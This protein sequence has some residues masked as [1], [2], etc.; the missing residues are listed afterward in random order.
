MAALPG[1]TA[2]RRPPRV[3]S[4]CGAS[5]GLGETW[6]LWIRSC[7]HW[8]ACTDSGFRGSAFVRVGVRK[9]PL[10]WRTQDTASA[11][12]CPVHHQPPELLRRPRQLTGRL[13][14]APAVPRVPRQG[15]IRWLDLVAVERTGGCRSG[16][17]RPGSSP[18]GRTACRWARGG[19]P[20]PARPGPRTW[21]PASRGRSRPAPSAWP[22][23]SGCASC[24]CGRGPAPSPRPAPRR[25]SSQLAVGRHRRVELDGRELLGEVGEDRL[26]EVAGPPL[27]VVGDEV[28]AQR[29]RRAGGAQALATSRPAGRLCQAPGR[30]PGPRRPEQARP[31]HPSGHRS[32]PSL[33][34]TPSQRALKRDLEVAMRR[35]LYDHSGALQGGRSVPDWPSCQKPPPMRGGHDA[36]G[37]HRSGWGS[38][39]VHDHRS[40]RPRRPRRGPRS[41]GNSARAGS[42]RTRLPAGV[43]FA[44]CVRTTVPTGTPVC[45]RGLVRPAVARRPGHLRGIIGHR[46]PDRRSNERRDRRQRAPGGQ[47]R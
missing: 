18:A 25:P 15:G 33:H 20:G 24:R 14:E 41:A 40:R 5:Y 22:R 36:D 45:L 38:G 10:F 39:R 8:N 4:C 44:C 29:A 23:G 6:Y 16:P 42:R 30:P 26:G 28:Q 34:G 7:I 19:G 2:S 13:Q 31:R 3:L 12:S 21:R 9:V 35:P 43:A 37:G 46:V 11:V 32:P 17:W 47:N 27:Q 1:R